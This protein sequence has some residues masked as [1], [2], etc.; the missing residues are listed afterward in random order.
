MPL[1]PG[2]APRAERAQL[3]LDL[4]DVAVGEDPVRLDALVDLAEVEVR[5]GVAAGARDAAL[6]VDDDV[7]DEP[8]AGERREGEDRGRRVAARA[9]R[10]SRPGRLADRGQLRAM[11][12]RAGRRRRW[13]SSSGRGWSKRYQRRVVGGVAEAEVRPEVD[14]GLPRVEELVDPRRRPSRAGGRGTRPRRRR[15][16]RRTPGGPWSRG[17]GGMPSIGSPWRSRPTRPVIWTLG[18]RARSRISSAPTYPVAPTIATRTGS[19]SRRAGPPLG[20]GRGRMG[21]GL[22]HGPPRSPHPSSP[23]SPARVAARG[24]QAR[25]SRRSGGTWSRE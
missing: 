20:G 12:L 18:W 16:P 9:S 15:G 24:R 6:G 25:G 7:V 13:P 14:H 21:G 22:T 19:P 3:L 11:E 17:W 1:T 4:A 5:L 2:L 8:R 10:R 23:R